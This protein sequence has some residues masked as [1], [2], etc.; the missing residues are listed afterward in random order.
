VE[1]FIKVDDSEDQ[2]GNCLKKFKQN[3]TMSVNSIN[4]SNITS[5]SINNNNIVTQNK[6]RRSEQ[7]RLPIVESVMISFYGTVLELKLKNMKVFN[8]FPIYQCLKTTGVEF[9]N[10]N[11][12]M[13]ELNIL[14]QSVVLVQFN[15]EK[16]P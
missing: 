13:E 1:I 5:T 8:V 3:P 9:Q 12:T 11:T 7:K 16:I 15:E 6:F 2:N 10:N 14:S 4:S